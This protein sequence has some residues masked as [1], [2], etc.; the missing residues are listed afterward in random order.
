MTYSPPIWFDLTN[1]GAGPKIKASDLNRIEQGILS[2]TTLADIHAATAKSTPADA[3]EFPLFDSAASFA[4]KKWTFANMK[5][6]LAA[7]LT[8]LT[9][10]WANKTLTSPVINAPTGIVKGDVGLGSADNT[11]DTAK[12][13]S[14]AQQN[15]L[16]L[17]APLASPTFTGTPTLPT[18]VINGTPTGTGVATAATASTLGLRDSNGNLLADNFIA[19]KAS[20]VNSGGTTTLTIADSQVQEFTGGAAQTVKLPTTGVPAGNPWTM[21]N[22]S[23]FTVSVQSSSGGAVFSLGAS[24]ILILTARIDNPTAAADWNITGYTGSE[25]ATARTAALRDSNAA[26]F[27]AHPPRQAPCLSGP[28][29]PRPHRR[30]V[31]LVRSLPTAVSS[32][33]VRPRTRGCARR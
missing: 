30:L 33:C 13:V 5:T 6:V 26:I 17:K 21:I 20:T 15:A 7:W 22:N 2:A 18:P 8:T 25:A 27:A 10:T 4:P 9:A 12:P 3:D 31:W 14:T 32:T 24:K 16:D 23:S 28:A 19:T 29:F 1:S 11:A